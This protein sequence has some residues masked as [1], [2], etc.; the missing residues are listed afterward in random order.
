MS[1]WCAD[2]DAQTRADLLI[3]TWIHSEY[4]SHTRC[5]TMHGQKVLFLFLLVCVC[6]CL[7]YAIPVGRIEKNKKKKINEWIKT[8]LNEKKKKK[9]TAS[10]ATIARVYKR[11]DPHVA[12]LSCDR[13]SQS[14][15]QSVPSY[16]KRPRSMRWTRGRNRVRKARE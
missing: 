12:I 6:V 15:L 16:I 5:D 7:R 13:S 3:R 8:G 14:C 2:S 10:L 11:E 4:I 9:L 1:F